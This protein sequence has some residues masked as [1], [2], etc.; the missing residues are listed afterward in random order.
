[1]FELLNEI[2]L[3]AIV[4]P[5]LFF[6]FLLIFLGVTSILADVLEKIETAIKRMNT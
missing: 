3:L 1:M 4:N 2:I 5:P 6:L